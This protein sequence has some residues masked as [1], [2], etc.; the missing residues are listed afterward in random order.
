[1]AVRSDR[2]CSV[3]SLS[4]S[5]SPVSRDFFLAGSEGSAS[6]SA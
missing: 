5:S 2:I 3:A 6:V 1:V 4:V